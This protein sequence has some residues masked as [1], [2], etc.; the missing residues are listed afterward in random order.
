MEEQKADVSALSF[1]E[2]LKSTPEVLAMVPL[3]VRHASPRGGFYEALQ[4]PDFWKL[5][6]ISRKLGLSGH[7]K[8]ANRK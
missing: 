3:A 1:A 6:E 2:F 5:F 4:V 8:A 7:P